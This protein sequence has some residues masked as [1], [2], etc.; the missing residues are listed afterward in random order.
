[1]EICET[2]SVQGCI[3]PRC[4]TC[5]YFSRP[6]MEC[7][8]HERPTAPSGDCVD[9]EPWFYE[10]PLTALQCVV[11]FALVWAMIAAAFVL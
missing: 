3:P 7:V 4:E 11:S 1:M 5:R 9:W 10:Q 8:K 6:V 2:R